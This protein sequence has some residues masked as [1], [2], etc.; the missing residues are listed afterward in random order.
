MEHWWQRVQ[1]EFVQPEYPSLSIP[2]TLYLSN[3]HQPGPSVRVSKGRKK[4]GESTI[5]AALPPLCHIHNTQAPRN[6]T[7]GPTFQSDQ[8]D[9]L[10]ECIP[11][12]MKHDPKSN[13]TRHFIRSTV[14]EFDVL[15]PL[16]LKLWPECSTET[17]YTD[18][19]HAAML[20]QTSTLQATRYKL[21][22]EKNKIGF[23]PTKWFRYWAAGQ[24]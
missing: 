3:S 12:Y 8:L 13:E 2:E 1:N 19:M 7:C 5:L 10:K 21:H 14:I 6:P 4:L 23:K 11:S 17:P 18:N 9:W 16:R 20:A 24:T 15:W 22:C